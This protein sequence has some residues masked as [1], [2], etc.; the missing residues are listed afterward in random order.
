MNCIDIGCP[1]GVEL[2]DV[3]VSGKRESV[4]KFLKILDFSMSR[5]MMA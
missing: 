2:T 4:A 5:F 1:F 3:D